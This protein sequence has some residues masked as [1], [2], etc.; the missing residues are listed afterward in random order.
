MTVALGG[1]D[2][3]LDFGLR[4]VLAAAKLGVRPPSRR[5]WLHCSVYGGSGYQLQ[6]GFRHRLQR[7]AVL[8]C[9]QNGLF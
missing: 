2:E 1:V 5:H 7:S 9:S 8:Y 3:P 6:V 4:Q